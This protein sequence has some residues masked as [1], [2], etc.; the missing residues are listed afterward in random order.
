MIRRSHGVPWTM[1]Y[2]VAQLAE[3]SRRLGVK[4]DVRLIVT[5]RPIGPAVFGLVRPSILLPEG[6][7]IRQPARAGRSSSLAAMNSST[8]DEAISSRGSFSS[9]RSLSGGFIP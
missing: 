6:A 4:R 3:L 7:A 2:V 8:S 9:S 5:S 1:R